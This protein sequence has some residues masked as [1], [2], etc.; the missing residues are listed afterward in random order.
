MESPRPVSPPGQKPPTG[1]IALVDS[2]PEAQRHGAELCVCASG[3]VKL[4]VL[5]ILP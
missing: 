4:E 5:L 3:L 1:F 2:C